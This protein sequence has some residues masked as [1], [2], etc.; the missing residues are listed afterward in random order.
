MKNP[1]ASLKEKSKRFGPK[2][3]SSAPSR[4]GRTSW[5]RLAHIICSTSFMT[6][7]EE[8]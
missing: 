6:S 4:S 1:G 3:I 5:L 2:A 7:P 8:N